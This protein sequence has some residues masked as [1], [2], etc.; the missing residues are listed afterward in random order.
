MG[1]RGN[2]RCLRPSADGLGV[3]GGT[4]S[5]GSASNEIGALAN[6][7]DGKCPAKTPG[8]IKRSKSPVRAVTSPDLFRPLEA[9]DVRQLLVILST[10]RFVVITTYHPSG[11]HAISVNLLVAIMPRRR[12]EDIAESQTISSSAHRICPDSGPC[13]HDDDYLP[14]AR[15][16]SSTRSIRRW[17]YTKSSNPAEPAADPLPPGPSGN[18]PNPEFRAGQANR[19]TLARHRFF[20]P[21]AVLPEQPSVTAGPN[22]DFPGKSNN[23]S[24]LTT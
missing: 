20:T 18:S 9:S 23:V 8:P 11:F 14:G 17:P 19:L 1:G 15:L 4:S 12:R 16:H 13:R 5:E 10:K 7:N 2:A 21:P 22:P 24:S 3:E 6:G